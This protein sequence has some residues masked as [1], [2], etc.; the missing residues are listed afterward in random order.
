MFHLFINVS[1]WQH[2][3]N[4]SL[5]NNNKGVSQ[6]CRVPAPAS[7]LCISLAASPPEHHWAWYY[8]LE[9]AHEITPLS[10]HH[11]WCNPKHNK[12]TARKHK[13]STRTTRSTK[14]P[15]T[16]RVC[17]NIIRS[18]VHI[19]YK[20]S[21]QVDISEKMSECCFQSRGD[22]SV[23]RAT[24]LLLSACQSC[25]LSCTMCLCRVRGGVFFFF[26]LPWPVSLRLAI[27]PIG[28]R[29]LAR[30]NFGDCKSRS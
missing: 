21:C 10:W 4:A 13:V 6:N 15:A 29:S 20:T 1:V 27:P 17:T 16:V 14:H 5:L 30:P 28:C 18:E 2:F 9:S 19:S 23:C 7:S 25:Q 12:S 22:E 8:F 11:A 26:F 24:Q 3:I